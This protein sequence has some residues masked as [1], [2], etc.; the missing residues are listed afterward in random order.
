MFTTSDGGEQWTS[1][2]T[3]TENA[4]YTITAAD[5]A[6]WIAGNRGI[7]MKY[8]DELKIYGNSLPALSWFRTIKFIDD[9][10]G[11]IVGGSGT[12]LKTSNG[13]DHWVAIK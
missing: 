9:Y 11:W 6:L 3:A 4:L 12:V 10:N 13:G 1:Y 5:G 7:L 8:G 2:T